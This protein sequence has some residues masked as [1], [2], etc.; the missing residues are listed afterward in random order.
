MMTAALRMSIRYCFN[1][2]FIDASMYRYM[3]ASNRHGYL[4]ENNL[5]I[6]VADLLND[7][8]WEMIKI[9]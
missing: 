4:F 9:N 2:N 8:F 7:E 5:S 3:K 1:H 6:V